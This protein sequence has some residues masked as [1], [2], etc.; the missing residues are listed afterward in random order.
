MSGGLV[1]PRC[2]TQVKYCL[3]H[4]Q[5]SG[6]LTRF[7]SFSNCSGGVGSTISGGCMLEKASLFVFLD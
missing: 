3:G 4:C 2:R 7:F 5:D 1:G 6:D